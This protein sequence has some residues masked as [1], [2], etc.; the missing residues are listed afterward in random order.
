MIAL[1]GTFF[2]VKKLLCIELFRSNESRYH[3][4]KSLYSDSLIVLECGIAELFK[5]LGEAFLVD[6]YLLADDDE[7]FF[8]PSSFIRSSS[9]IFSPGLRPVNTIGTSL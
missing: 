5:A 2:Q 9:F 3:F 7:V 6:V 4:M 8:S 1:F